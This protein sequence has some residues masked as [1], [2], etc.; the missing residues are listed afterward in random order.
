VKI[1][2]NF[3][4]T[5][6]GLGDLVKKVERPVSKAVTTGAMQLVNESRR[7]IGMESR[8][9]EYKRGR[10]TR[11]AS[12][13]PFPPNN[14]TGFLKRSITMTK[15]GSWVVYVIAGARYASSL[16]EGT[17]RMKPRPFMKPSMDR[18]EPA[19]RQRIIDAYNEA[20]K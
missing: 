1:S 5:V 19:I 15:K 8:G 13:H 9:R 12:L 17:R 14:Q 11:V 2:V 6:K 10:T 4:S 16:E 7:R 18:T 20:L 3:D